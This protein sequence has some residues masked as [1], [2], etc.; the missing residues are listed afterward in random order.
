M[1][2]ACR[3]A[4]STTS[5]GFVLAMAH[6]FQHSLWA[7]SVE[8]EGTIW[9]ELLGILETVEKPVLVHYGSYETTFLRRMS[10][11]H[12]KPLK[13]SIVAATIEAAVNL[14]S[15]IFAQVYYPC[16]SN[17][18]KDIAKHLGFRWSASTA[19][20]TGTIVWHQ[21]WESSR[22]PAAKE[23]ILIYNAEDCQAL[24]VVSNCLLVTGRI[25]FARR[26]QPIF[27]SPS[28]I[29]FLSDW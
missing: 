8:D 11:R 12:G 29:L 25:V 1:S 6:L 2:R 20:G 18:L 5:L 28:R 21:E 26:C 23:A 19:T 13:G 27:R 4:I 22:A 3:T 15:V 24:E 7:D 10:E 16:H 17:G 9:L 14:L